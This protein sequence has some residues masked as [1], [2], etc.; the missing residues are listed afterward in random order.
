MNKLLRITYLFIAIV[1]LIFISTLSYAQITIL[2]PKERPLQAYHKFWLKKLLDKKVEIEYHQNSNKTTYIIL[3]ATKA[4]LKSKK[5]K[6]KAKVDNDIIVLLHGKNGRKEDLLPLCERYLAMGFVCI[7][8]DLPAHGDSKLSKFKVDNNYLDN[9][10]DDASKYIDF[11]DKKIAIWGFSLGSAVAVKCVAHSKYRFNAMVLVSTFDKLKSVVEEKT[12]QF[13]G[14]FLAKEFDLALYSSLKSF[15]NFD[16]ES[17][18]SQKYAKKLNIPVLIIH[19]Q[20]DNIVNYKRAEALY[21]SFASSKKEFLLNP[22]SNHNT[23]LNEVLKDYS[24]NSEFLIEE[25]NSI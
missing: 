11:K 9:I 19:G 3:K 13:L 5:S 17:L 21:K 12:S 25:L 2:Y 1:I 23:I 15:W 8:P 14:G 18:D 24:K 7:L 6:H 20:K 4:S 22:N 16:I 10:L